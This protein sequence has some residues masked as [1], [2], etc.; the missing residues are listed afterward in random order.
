MARRTLGEDRTQGCW[1]RIA[2]AGGAG[3]MPGIP[4]QV[5]RASEGFERLEKQ[6]SLTTLPPPSA[7]R[8]SGRRFTP[9]DPAI[10]HLP[11]APHPPRPS[12]KDAP[13]PSVHAGGSALPPPARQSRARALGPSVSNGATS[14]LSSP[15]TLSQWLF[16]RAPARRCP[17][18]I[19][20]S[21]V[22]HAL[23]IRESTLRTA[24][25]PR[26]HGGGGPVARRPLHAWSPIRRRSR[27]TT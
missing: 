14:H 16:P 15:S 24:A 11:C 20:Q 21:K 10:E 12:G 27:R 22:E 7:T 18:G 4:G 17:P 26:R 25:R 8:V 19:S 5:G 9:G 1:T 13:S 6:S 2:G 23:F 3:S